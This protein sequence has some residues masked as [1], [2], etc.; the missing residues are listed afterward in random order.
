[1]SSLI[2]V[3]SISDVLDKYQFFDNLCRLTF[4]NEMMEGK[5]EYYLDTTDSEYPALLDYREKYFASL[6]EKS[7]E[8]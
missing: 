3:K 6:C 4:L 1:M 8:E 5:G 2:Q 7:D